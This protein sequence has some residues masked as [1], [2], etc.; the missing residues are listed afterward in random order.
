MSSITL[1]YDF[2]KKPLPTSV[3]AQLTRAVSMSTPSLHGISLTEVCVA[4]MWSSQSTFVSYYALDGLSR[5]PLL[6]SHS[7]GG[8]Y[9]GGA[10]LRGS[11]ALLPGAPPFHLFFFP[12][13]LLTLHWC[14]SAHQPCHRIDRHAGQQGADSAWVARMLSGQPG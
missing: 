4:A 11:P 9:R 1:C 8:A 13:V 6:H 10:P 3:K 14:W 12:L 2:S 5:S 7:H